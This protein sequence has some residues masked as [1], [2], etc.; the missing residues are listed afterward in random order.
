ML[1][2][3]IS[4]L[5]PVDNILYDDVLLDLAEKGVSGE[6]LRL[7]ES[8]QTFIVLG[9]TGKIVEDVVEAAAERDHVPVIRR[10]SGGG[11]V[12]QGPGC[13]NYS[14]ILSKKNDAALRDI[15]KSY[16]IIL[17]KIAGMMRRLGIAVVFYPVSDLARDP[18]ARKVSGN[19]QRRG[20]DFILHHGTILL[21]FDLSLVERYLTVPR[22]APAY[23]KGRAHGDFLANIH[24]PL[25]DIKQAFKAHFS[26]SQSTESLTVSEA[27]CL[28]VYR[29]TKSVMIA[30]APGET[31]GDRA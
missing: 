5:S 27:A 29:E 24:V 14:L 23:R 3:D 31:G 19:A 28:D 2:K 20:R 9:K 18:G 30:T 8:P 11:T 13:L 22:R 10:S 6:S 15:T 1:L 25:T 12:V 16:R 21:D 4:F 17:E 7:W 26:I